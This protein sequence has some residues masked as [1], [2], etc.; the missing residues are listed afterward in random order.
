[1][2]GGKREKNI[3]VR[4]CAIDD[5]VTMIYIYDLD[6]INGSVVRSSKFSWKSFMASL[7]QCDYSF[8]WLYFDTKFCAHQSSQRAS[9]IEVF[10]V[11]RLLAI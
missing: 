3:Y 11:L 6:I 8:I 5:T 4:N 10:K 1:M 7:Q 2:H 9:E